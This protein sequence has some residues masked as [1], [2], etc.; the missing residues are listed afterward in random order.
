MK[1][2]KL[3]TD[4]VNVRQ[5]Y[6]SLLTSW[7]NQDAIAF[8]GLFMHNGHLIG[9]DGSQIN[10]Q[11]EITNELRRIFAGHAAAPFVAIVREVRALSESVFLLRAVAGMIPPGGNDINPKLNTV[12]TLIAQKEYG[13]F[14]IT[15]FQNTPAA[16]H[17]RPDLSEELTNELSEAAKKAETVV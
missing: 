7:N 1:I 8:A 11:V 12:H 3:Q 10:G 6:H 14:Y 15:L 4:R 2:E 5:L 16:L 17:E 9:F 13:Q